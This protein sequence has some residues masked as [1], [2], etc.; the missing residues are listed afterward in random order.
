MNRLLVSV[1]GSLLISGCTI[2]GLQNKD[3]VGVLVDVGDNY[4][5]NLH[6]HAVVH[7]NIVSVN[8]IKAVTISTEKAWIGNRVF[9]VDSSCFEVKRDVRLSKEKVGVADAINAA[10]IPTHYE[11]GTLI[12]SVSA[13]SCS[14]Y[15]LEKTVRTENL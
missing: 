11:V 8:Y 15:E 9:K 1:F 13:V 2:T 3:D 14:S 12:E 5:T 10:A 4:N 6:G 7:E